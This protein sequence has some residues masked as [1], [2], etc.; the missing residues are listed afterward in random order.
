VSVA[1][2]FAACVLIW[3]STWIAITFQLGV[4]APEASVA[5]RFLLAS[6]LL[7]GYCI[8]RRMPLRFSGRDHLWIMLQG[9]LMFS[10]GYVF[11]YY[12][13]QHIVSGIVAVGYSASPLINLALMRLFFG[14][15]MSRRV[16]L[17]GVLGLVGI[18][19]V[20]WPEFA[21]LDAGS[22]TRAG[23]VFALASVII[24]ALGSMV[25]HRNQTAGLPIWQTM[26]WGMF[27]GA[28]VT[29]AM[30]LVMGRSFAFLWTP[31]YLLSLGY[32]AVFGSILAF[33]GFLHLLARVGAARASYVG[34]MVPIVALIVSSVFEGYRWEALALAGVAISVAGN[35]IILRR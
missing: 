33:S 13:E 6:L 23:I 12:A 26:A 5:Y 32:L 7:F 15:A 19:L 16:A 11:V 30:A 27:Y 17:G 24:S 18:M 22:D 34:V 35:V 9:V 25:A 20:F 4:V 28:G 29:F 21:R 3:G 2:L 14:K 10:V 31:G 8:A 1:Q